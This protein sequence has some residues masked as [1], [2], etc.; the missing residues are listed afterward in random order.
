MASF[1][2]IVN[3]FGQRNNWLNAKKVPAYAQNPEF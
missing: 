2:V 1:E 3:D